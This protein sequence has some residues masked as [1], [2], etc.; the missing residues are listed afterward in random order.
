MN[1]Y[2]IYF[3]HRGENYGVGYLKEGNAEHIAKVV[4]SKLG[5][6]PLFEIKPMKEYSENYRKCCDEAKIESDSD[7]RPEIEK[8]LPNLDGYNDIYLCYPC[9]WGSFP[10]EVATFLDNYDLSGKRIHPIC[11]HEGSMMGGSVSELKKVCPNSTIG[12]GLAILGR[13]AHSSDET[14]ADWLEGD[15]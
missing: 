15:K 8:P 11:T 3:S 5:G 7:S 9:W 4:S 12:T 14:I 6:A 13:K 1:S 2:V 10:R